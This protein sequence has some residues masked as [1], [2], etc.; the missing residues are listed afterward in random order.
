[1]KN[2]L[3]VVILNWNGQH[4]LEK[5]LPGVVEHSTMQGVDVVVADN[6]SDDDS[7]KWLN[8]H[9]KDKVEILQFDKNHGFAGG[10]NLVFQ[11]V[12]AEYICLLNSDVEIKHPWI[13]PA[14]DHLEKHDDTGVVCAKLLDQRNP[15]YFEYASAAG[16]YIDKYG[17]PFC[18]GR[19]FEHVE[20]DHGQYDEIHDV[21]WGAGAALFFRRDLWNAHDGLDEDFF[22]HMEEIDLC[23][24]IKNSGKRVVCVPQSVVYHVGGGTLPK[25][26][27]RKTFLNFRNNLWMLQKNLPPK[28]YKSVMFARFWLDIL[29]A[30]SFM[31]S[32]RFKDTGAVVKAWNNVRKTHKQTM[33]KRR[34]MQAFKSNLHNAGFY[35]GSI[36]WQYHVRKRKR[37][38]DIN[39]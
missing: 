1:M 18:R 38:S 23:W 14:L 30:V 37:F 2:K 35:N 34:Q 27:P 22:A 10:Y 3:A 29:A 16:G 39:I 17:Y 21:L 28:R 9:Y 26:E 4:F 11:Q 5:F 7:V 32:G 33:E 36:L 24:R 6:A 13:E 12:E 31:F 19:I 8:K 15:A 20:K 25:N